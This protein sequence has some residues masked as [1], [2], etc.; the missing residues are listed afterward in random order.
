MGK[1]AGVFSKSGFTKSAIDFA[2]DNEVLLVRYEPSLAGFS[3]AGRAAIANGL[4]SFPSAG[5]G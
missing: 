1:R 3:K 2:D 5:S 4:G